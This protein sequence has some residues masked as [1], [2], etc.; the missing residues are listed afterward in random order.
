MALVIRCILRKCRWNNH[1]A[2][3]PLSP[4]ARLGLPSIALVGECTCKGSKSRS[5]LSTMRGTDSVVRCGSKLANCASSW[6]NTFERPSRVHAMRFKL[7]KNQ[8][9]VRNSVRTNMTDD[10]IGPQSWYASCVCK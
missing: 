2:L 7:P 9:K 3:G 10:V 8:P 4:G 5:A 6:S 1:H